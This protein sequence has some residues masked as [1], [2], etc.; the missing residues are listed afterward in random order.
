MAGGWLTT[1]VL[2]TAR[3]C[4]AAG[5]WVQ[6]CR[7]EGRARE[8]LARMVTN[9]DGRTDVVDADGRVAAV[10]EQRG[11]RVQD[12]IAPAASARRRQ[13]G[14]GERW[15]GIGVEGEHT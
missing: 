10:G 3:G 9:A 7:S 14:C 4:P 11:C 1:H 8:A 12:L 5:L 2:D 15:G 13:G 6:L